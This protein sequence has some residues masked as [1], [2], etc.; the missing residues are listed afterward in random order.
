[1]AA[2]KGGLKK[3]HNTPTRKSGSRYPTVFNKKLI[4]DGI[5]FFVCGEGAH[6]VDI[7][8]W[9]AG[10]NMPLNE[11]G[12]PITEEGDFDY[13]LDLFVHQNVG[14]MKQPYVCPYENFG[15]PCP[16]CEF[17]N[18]TRPEKK[19]WSKIRA[20]RR[21]IYLIWDR[22]TAE[23]EKKGVQIFDAAHFFMEEKILEIA[24]LPREGGFEVF[25]DPDEGK[26][27]CWTRK[28]SGQEN[29]QYLGHRFIDR[30]API[31]DRILES[32]FSLDG[33]INMHPTYD[34]IDREF[35]GSAT[36]T[37][38]TSTDDDLPF[39][40]DTQKDVPDDN[41]GKTNRTASNP[42]P[43]KKVRRVVRRVKK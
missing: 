17:I 32:T 37:D 30:E 14:K 38:K 15:K 23:K 9:E 34:E 11:Q 6:I 42:K 16:I 35:N 12:D 3:R 27:V 4:P 43:K 24:K 20:K 33:V 7:L 31:P 40:N 5:S 1:M 10:A 2:R 39:D 25:S 26:S 28:G 8:P 22:T 41:V 18:D 13:V 29:T 21:S 19:V 36:K